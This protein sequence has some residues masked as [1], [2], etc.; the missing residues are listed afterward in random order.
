MSLITPCEIA[1]MYKLLDIVR[2]GVRKSKTEMEE[3][4]GKIMI[5]Y[6][7]GIIEDFEKELDKE[8]DKELEND[9][10]ENK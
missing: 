7:K 2:A 9:S 10:G 4:I 5:G 1:G 3:Q 6:I 8:I